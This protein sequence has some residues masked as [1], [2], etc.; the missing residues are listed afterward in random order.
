MERR[1]EIMEDFYW[2][3]LV[4]EKS[5]VYI[6]VSYQPPLF[7]SVRLLDPNFNILISKNSAS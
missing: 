3:L 2:P 4:H 5:S 6:L 7:C 1:V